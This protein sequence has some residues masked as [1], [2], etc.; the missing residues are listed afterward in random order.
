MNKILLLVSLAL[1]V[2]FSQDY[3]GGEL[4]TKNSYL[5][6]RFEATFKSAQGDGLVSS[7]FTYQDELINGTHIWNEIDIEVLGRW[8]NIVNMNTITPGNSSHLSERYI[9]KFDAHNGYHDYAF[10][11]TPSYVAWFIDGKEWYRQSLSDHPQISTLKH[12]QKI[13]MNLWVP[14]YEDWVGIW[15]EKVIPRFSFYDKVTYYKYTPDTGSSG[16]NNNFTLDWEDS[17]DSF[18]SNRWEKASHSFSGNRVKFIS[19]NVVFDNGKMILCLTNKSDLG[20]QDRISPEPLFGYS[21]N[22]I[23]T[24]RFSEELDSSAALNKFNYTI[25]NLEINKIFLEKDLRTVKVFSKNMNL[26]KTYRVFLSGLKDNFSNLIKPQVVQIKN[27]KPVNIPFKVNIGGKRSDDFSEDKFWWHDFDAYGH[28]NGNN[29]DVGNINIK[30]TSNDAIYQTSAERIAVYKV[31][32]LPGIYDITLMF[33]DNYYA[34]NQRSFSVRLEGEEKISNIDISKTVGKHTALDKRFLYVP[35]SD[36]ILNI[37][38]DLELYG[39]GYGAAGPFLNGLIIERTA[40]LSLGDFDIPIS[41]KLGDTYPNPFNNFVT[42]SI[43]SSGDYELTL[44]IIDILGRQVDI[45]FENKKLNRA[46]LIKWD[47]KNFTSG[48]YYVRLQSKNHSQLKKISLLK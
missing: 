20:Y 40:G 45:L 16:T 31:R 15:N 36:G 43:E 11:W 32:L 33:S 18:D 9:E 29:Q 7:F 38:F 39:N 46:N 23:I 47:A 30:N 19:E 41:Y 26:A 34:A 6:G 5:Y 12:A 44:D 1:S 35:V 21:E 17:F 8:S 37:H 4:R 24:I 3:F 10:E 27:I 2:V 28:M 13:M 25:N 22:N 14:I 42:I 48:I